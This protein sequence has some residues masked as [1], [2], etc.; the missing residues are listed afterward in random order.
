MIFT[1]TKYVVA[2]G[3][4]SEEIVHT[5]EDR[6]SALGILALDE[7]N[8]NMYELCV[9]RGWLPVGATKTFYRDGELETELV[10]AVHENVLNALN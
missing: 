6:D 1:M 2:K 9:K 4:N 10:L 3:V 8:H 7:S 5:G